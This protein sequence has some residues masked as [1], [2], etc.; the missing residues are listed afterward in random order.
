MTGKSEY[1]QLKQ[2]LSQTVK[3]AKTQMFGVLYAKL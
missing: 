1:S 3:P 2:S